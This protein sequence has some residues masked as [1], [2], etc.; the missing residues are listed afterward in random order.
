MMNSK[1]KGAALVTSLVLLA[2]LTIVSISAMTSTTAQLQVVG[3]DELT[4]DAYEQAQSVV[5]AIIDQNG[6]FVLQG[7][8]GYTVC[9]NITGCD[10]STSI[11][12]SDSIFSGSAVQAKVTLINSNATNLRTANASSA[13]NTMSVLYTVTGSYDNTGQEQGKAEITQG[14]MLTIP[15]S[16]QN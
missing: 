11:T 6:P 12:L 3:N 5:D 9:Y 7:T 10:N 15:K 16:A 1:T 4:M 14:Y 8:N 2:A 13:A